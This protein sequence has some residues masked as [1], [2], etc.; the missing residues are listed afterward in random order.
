M[1]PLSKVLGRRW[2]G[3][4]S[5]ERI[6]RA[7]ESVEIVEGKNGRRAVLG[8]W[9]TEMDSP[10]RIRD[11]KNLCGW[12]NAAVYR[13]WALRSIAR[14]RDM[15]ERST[16]R[17]RKLV[18]VGRPGES[19]DMFVLAVE[20]LKRENGRKIRNMDVDLTPRDP[21]WT[22]FSPVW[23]MFKGLDV[24]I[25]ESE[26]VRGSPGV[27]VGVEAGTSHEIESNRAEFP[28]GP[29]TQTRDRYSQHLLAL[30]Q[31]QAQADQGQGIP[32]HPQAFAV[33]LGTPLQPLQLVPQPGVQPLVPVHRPAFL[34][35]VP[36]PGQP[37]IHRIMVAPVQL[38]LR[39]PLVQPQKSGLAPVARL[40]VHPPAAIGFGNDRRPNPDFP[41]LPPAPGAHVGP[42]LIQG[43]DPGRLP[44][45]ENP[46]PHQA[47]HQGPGGPGFFLTSP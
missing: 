44:A 4:P 14:D 9:A 26:A 33:P 1:L 20:S 31:P 30:N 41:P 25:L 19:N 40:K 45:P 21:E 15:L 39:Q 2:P 8:D 47:G 7:D 23:K 6:L 36:V 27:V 37:L 5:D 16:D 3:V 38:R 18:E 12:Y 46:F 28:K 43:D 32:Q 42:H 10:N 13:L 17:F 29:A 24:A 22:G 34:R 11:A 35:H